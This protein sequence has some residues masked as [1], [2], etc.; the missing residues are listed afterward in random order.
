MYFDIYMYIAPSHPEWIYL[1]QHT[2][3]VHVV[4]FFALQWRPVPQT[5]QRDTISE[6]DT[7]EEELVCI[8]Y[9]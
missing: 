9:L 7:E 4:L 1:D 8:L 5:K 3:N 6:K 2:T